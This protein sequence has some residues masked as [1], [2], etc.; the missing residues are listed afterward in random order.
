MKLHRRVPVCRCLLS[1]REGTAETLTVLRLGV[2][3]TLARTL[4][5]TNAIESISRLSRPL[6]E[7]QALAERQM[8]LRWCAA[9]MIEARGSSA[10]STA[11]HTC[12]RY[13]LHSSGM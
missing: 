10:A 12:P 6:Q 13:A 1:L 7:R 9:G 11:T 3:L 5:S 2:P 4:R 8:A